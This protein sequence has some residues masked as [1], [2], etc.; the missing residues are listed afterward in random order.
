MKEINKNDLMFLEDEILGDIKKVENKLDNKIFAIVESLKEQKNV[1]EKKLNNLEII[2]NILKVKT[3]NLK[4]SEANEKEINSKINS[5]NMK[6]EDYFSKLDSRIAL[7]QTKFQEYCYK[8]DKAIMTNFQIPGLIGERCPYSSI[9]DFYENMHKKIN[10]SLRHKEQQSI[11]LKK[12]KEKMEVVITQNKTH[13]PMFENKITNYFDKQIND[14]DNKY[15]ESVDIIEERLSKMRI[16]NGKYTN[17]LIEKCNEL[18]NK[19]TKIDDILKN[20]LNQYNEELTKYKNSFKD[21]NSKLE[22]F[23]E[24]YNIFQEEFKNINW[25]NETVKQ[26]KNNLNEYENKINEINNK[27]TKEDDIINYDENKIKSLN[28]LINDNVEKSRNTKNEYYN[29]SKSNYIEYKVQNEEREINSLLNKKQNK[30]TEDIVLKKIKVKENNIKVR[31]RNNSNKKNYS[32][33]LKKYK[34]KEKENFFDDNYENTRIN[35][36]IFDSNFFESSNYIGNYY[37]NDYCSKYNIAKRNKKLFNRVKS[38]KISH[39]FPFITNDNNNFDDLINKQRNST[40]DELDLNESG[41]LKDEYENNKN[42][43]IYGNLYGSPKIIKRKFESDLNENY[44]PPGH[45]FLYLDRKIDILSNA[46]VDSINKIIFQINY[47]K[48]SFK[49]NNN[50]ISLDEKNYE[51]LTFKKKN[52]KNSL[53]ETKN[54]SNSPSYNDISNIKKASLDKKRNSSQKYKIISKENE[55]NKK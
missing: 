29:L 43:T 36:I 31:L 41:K 40:P 18:G 24:Q 32:D 52:I 51:K 7:L 47:I 38:G 10:E 39:I 22:K 28:S 25:L 21:M 20:S 34:K 50:Q 45:K 30:N 4:S 42:S 33:L 37:I 23:E 2:Y 44:F 3:Q 27:I 9:R 11:D 13:L 17:D 16:E 6:I 5:L 53:L 19:C 35:N 12:Y 14:I 48:K 55:N 8:Y 46:M 15:K 26:M 49:N 1:Y 54:L